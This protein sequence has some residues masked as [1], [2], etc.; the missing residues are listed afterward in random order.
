MIMWSLHIHTVFGCLIEQKKKVRK[1]H[2]PS[3]VVCHQGQ[4]AYNRKKKL[5]CSTRWQSSKSVGH[6]CLL[7]SST[8]ITCVSFFNMCLAINTDVSCS[9]KCGNSIGHLSTTCMK[10]HMT[11]HPAAHWVQHK[12]KMYQKKDHTLPLFFSTSTPSIQ[13]SF[14][15]ASN[16]GDVAY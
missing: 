10:K 11:S 7:V 13:A 15:T 8:E 16:D 9:L 14:L 4:L 5:S 1:R 6:C 12:I 2:N 3:K